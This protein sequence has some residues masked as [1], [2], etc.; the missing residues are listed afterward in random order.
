L[1]RQV[2]LSVLNRFYPII[3]GFIGFCI[4]IVATSRFNIGVSRDSIL[5]IGSARNLSNGNGFT[6]WTGSPLTT[7]APLYPLIL[8]A[9]DYAFKIDP[10][11]SARYVNAFIFGLIVYTSGLLFKKHLK[12]SPATAFLGTISVLFSFVLVEVSIKAM[13][14]A[15][16]ICFILIYLLFSEIYI[17]KRNILSLSISA[18]AI[19][20]AALTRYVGIPL[21]I[22][23]IFYILLFS[24]ENRNTKF[25]HISL[26]LFISI[27]PIAAW[28]IRNSILSGFWFGNNRAQITVDPV[29]LD[30]I[31][32]AARDF[33]YQS[34]WWYIPERITNLPTNLPLLVL[35]LGP[36]IGFIIVKEYKPNWIIFSNLI[37]FYPILLMTTVYMG[38][39]LLVMGNNSRI[40]HRYFLPVFVP[41]TLLLF[42]FADNVLKPFLGRL[43]PKHGN[44]LFLAFIAIW[45]IY[46]A[47]R[48][49]IKLKNQYENGYYFTGDLWKN[50][51]IIEYISQHRELEYECAIYSNLSHALYLLADIRTQ[52]S[53]R[54][55]QD[56]KVI[57]EI[58]SLKGDWPSENKGCLIWFDEES[59]LR[60]KFFLPDELMSI[61]DVDWYLRFQD[62]AI[63]MFS[64]N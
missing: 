15:L 49:I 43:S 54:N 35:I 30:G 17:E 39:L 57:T 50:S 51:E 20:L 38:F 63:Y 64:K 22:T 13:T 55:D 47:Q 19:S 27:T 31:Y 23:G 10:L 53:P 4:I 36:I 25:Q 2:L 16:F 18:L 7:A 58:A 21:I 62:G 1:K 3:L 34:L 8:A 14:E 61:V 33:F 5:Y 41:L 12:S 45:L 46:P 9:I 24:R 32:L 48:T 52:Y 6:S 60:G 26:Y 44:I 37:T 28:L 42:V 40:V 56:G 29:I 11:L 59:S